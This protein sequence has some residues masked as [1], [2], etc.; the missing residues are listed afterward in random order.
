M[1]CL[2]LHYQQVRAG[3][4]WC[5]PPPHCPIILMEIYLYCNSDCNNISISPK[6]VRFDLRNGDQG[7]VISLISC[8]ALT[9]L[10]E[11]F[12]R[13]LYHCS[14]SDKIQLYAMALLKHQVEFVKASTERVK[15]LIRLMKHWFKTSFA[16][17]GEEN[18]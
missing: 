9:G 6:S 7:S 18:K 8:L 12:Y 10:K 16:T 13:K 11:S 2:G 1:T 4:G 3:W 5:L 14:D 17:P 15:D